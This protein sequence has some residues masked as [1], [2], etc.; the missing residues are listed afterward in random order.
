[1]LFRSEP[2][3]GCRLIRSRDQLVGVVVHVK[4]VALIN[5]LPC[6]I[7]RSIAHELNHCLSYCIELLWDGRS[8]LLSLLEGGCKQSIVEHFSMMRYRI[9]EKSI[10]REAASL[11]KPIEVLG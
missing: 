11:R 4:G 8:M 7:R 10:M 3:E 9:S 2:V 5:K 1:M 6:E